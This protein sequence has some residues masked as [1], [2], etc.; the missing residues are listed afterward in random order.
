MIEEYS[1]KH[2]KS[3]EE[4]LENNWET[5]LKYLFPNYSYVDEYLTE[6]S[7]YETSNIITH[8]SLFKDS[9]NG[10]ISF[11]VDDSNNM[12]SAMLVCY[13]KETNGSQLVFGRDI[14]ESFKDISSTTDYVKII[15][16]SSNSNPL[17]KNYRKIINKYG[18]RECGVFRSNILNQDGSRDDETY[19]EIETS[20]IRKH[21]KK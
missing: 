11:Y 15:F 17:L 10:I 7:Y 1:S 5:D 6:L 8:V 21:L 3:V 20:A 4:Y 19:F 12:I 2:Y 16:S 18:G 13:F 9:L 14:Y